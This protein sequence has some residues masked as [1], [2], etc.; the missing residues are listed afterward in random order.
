M[1][2]VNAQ[3]FMLGVADIVTQRSILCYVIM[4]SDVMLSVAKLCQSQQ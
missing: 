1:S 3:F 2:V 4:Q